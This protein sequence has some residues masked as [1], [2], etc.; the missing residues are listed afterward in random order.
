MDQS[1]KKV[2]IIGMGI[3]GISALREWT[4][5]KDKNPALE[6]TAFGDAD[7]FGRGMPYQKDDDLLIMNQPAELATIIPEN[8]DDFVEWLEETQDEKNPRHGYY[9][10][11]LFGS[12]LFD[13]MKKWLTESNAE[14]IK[15]KVMSIQPLENRKFRVTTLSHREDF[16]VVHLCIGLAPYDD[17]YE[18]VGHPNFILDPFP[19]NKQLADIPQG[20]K[21]GVLGTGLTSIDILRYL[22]E[23]RPD[24]ALSFYSHSGRFK[25]ARGETIS[26]DYQYFT[27]ENIEKAK[28]E[29]GGFIPLEIYIEWFQ[30]EL[31]AQGVFLDSD[32]IDQPFGSKENVERDLTSPHEIGVVQ[33]LILGMDRFLTDIWMALTEA[34]KARFVDRYGEQWDKVRSSFPVE[35]GEILYA[36]WDA[37]KISVFADVEEIIEQDQSFEIV[38]KDQAAQSVDYLINAAGT[39]NNVNFQTERDPLLHQ[40]LNER[41]LQPEPFGGIQITVP[42]LSVVS[43]RYGV[44]DRFKAHGPLISGIQFGNNSIDI[45]SEGVQ[46]AVL[47]MM[48]K[49]K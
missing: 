21:V 30:Q 44:L 34:D 35:S 19:V 25:T 15:E 16:D 32:W 1:I 28:A 33:T 10:R 4:K 36:L 14:T 20:A 3:A 5:Q 7:T 8:P 29:N 39:E 26:F 47:D 49:N 22:N 31:A 37:E 13:R 23:K 11:A 48:T 27:P 6:I 45:I 38:L 40:L 2:A 9:P 17:P 24:I 41:V 46:T 18:L 42:N 43:Q 12:Y